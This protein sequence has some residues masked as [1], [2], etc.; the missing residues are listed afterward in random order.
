MNSRELIREILSRASEPF[1][2]YEPYFNR[3]DGTPSWQWDFLLAAS[4]YK[5]RVALGANRIGKSEQ[6]AYE[7]AL[8]VT[9]QHPARDFPAHGIGWIIGL[10]N[11]MIRDIDRPMFEKFLPQRFKT[12]YYKQDN[13]WECY[14]D[15]RMW[16]IVFKSTEMGSDKFQGAKI[17]FAWFDEEPKRTEIFNE[18]E[19]R[20]IDNRGVWWMTA[21][22]I[23]GT[24]WL[25][26]LSERYDVYKTFAGMREN[27]YLPLAEVEEMAKRLP[28]DERMV[29]IEGQ[30]IIFGGRPIFNRGQLMAFHEKAK[31]KK[32]EQ[33]I[34]Q[35]A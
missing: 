12:K 22:P 34:L 11:A 3:T 15:D 6:G 27:P 32:F 33:G 7:T 30:Y 13:I 25:K 1:Y 21:T 8:A 16:K 23:R 17:D 2:R 31:K 28:E 26:D 29:R 35:V 4:E 14:C 5:G 18:V 19:T 10:D 20:L 24:K 9:G